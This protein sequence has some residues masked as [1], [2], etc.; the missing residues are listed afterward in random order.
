MKIACISTSH[1]PST[2]AN[3]IQVMKACQQMRLLGHDLQLFVPGRESIAF[4]DLAEQYGLHQ[5]FGIRWVPAWNRLKRYDF[6]WSAVVEAIRWRADLIYTWTP[7]AA[8]FAVWKNKATVLEMHDRATGRFGPKVVRNFLS[9]PKP[10]KELVC[11]T[12][13]LKNTLEEQLDVTIPEVQVV[14]APNGVDM[15]RYQ[16]LPDPREARRQLGLAE[17]VTVSYTGH[18]YAGRGVE[19][20]FELARALSEVQ[21]LWIG[22]R[23]RELAGVQERLQDEVLANVVLTGFIDNQKLPLYQAASDVLIM[24]YERTIAGSS[25]GNSADICSPMKMFEYMASGR[26]IIS[27]DLPVI[28]EVL[29]DRTAYFCPPEDVKAWITCLA[30]VLRNPEKAKLKGQAA[31]ELMERYTIQIRQEQILR[32]FIGL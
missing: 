14:I 23:D 1:V 3:S 24:P 6:A 16:N 15:E 21:F 18:F 11:V 19:I 4:S 2:T 32:K 22:G 27:S 29:D 8:L 13:A 26:T 30:E 12:R 5:E 20:L 25:G 10:E 17:K 28:R 9:H 7:Q 31:R